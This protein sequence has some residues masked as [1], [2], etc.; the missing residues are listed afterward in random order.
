[1]GMIQD[2]KAMVKQAMLDRDDLRKSIL[3]VALGDL[4][5]QA[6]RL[7]DDITDAQ[8]EQVIRKMVKSSHEMIK[9]SK[10][11]AVVEK[12]KAELVI[13]ESLLPQTLSVEEIKAALAS[14]I[15][16]IKAVGN[17]GQATGVAMKH[18]KSN[19]A[20]VVG[21]DVSQ[22]VRELRAS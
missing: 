12:T 17:D 13:L 11:P 6:L 18:L 16:D 5:T 10:D 8:C 20:V 9:L 2:I 15:D 19:G 1:M 4:E 14:V 21:K 3:K 7:K 22:A